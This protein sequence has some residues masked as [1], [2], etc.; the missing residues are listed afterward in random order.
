[1]GKQIL[2]ENDYFLSDIASGKYPFSACLSATE[3]QAPL[4]SF[5]ELSPRRCSGRLCNIIRAL[6]GGGE[7]LV[8]QADLTFFL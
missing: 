8:F 7:C 1:M 2:V 4:S 6:W 5:P 3:L